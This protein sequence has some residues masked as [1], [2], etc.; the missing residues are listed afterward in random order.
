MDMVK[1]F[2]LVMFGGVVAAFMAHSW[3][4][5]DR[6]NRR[7]CGC[8]PGDRSP[9]AQLGRQHELHSVCPWHSD[10]RRG[11]NL[12]MRTI[13]A[14]VLRGRSNRRR[15]ELDHQQVASEEKRSE[16]KERVGPG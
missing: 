3:A 1:L 8:Q 12:S 10:D 15:T 4:P 16:A 9:A 5:F 13:C 2:G 6:H 11:N 14:T 7:H